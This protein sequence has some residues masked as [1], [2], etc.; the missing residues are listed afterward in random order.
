[1]QQ[2]LRLRALHL[3][4]KDREGQRLQRT[5]IPFGE[6]PHPQL[7]GRAAGDELAEDRKFGW[8]LFG[9]VPRPANGDG[10]PVRSGLSGHNFTNG[11]A[12]APQITGNGILCFPGKIALVCG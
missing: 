6:V 7:L 11:L 8:H 1:M 3:D 10:I 2:G 4:L 5:V 9:K 12:G